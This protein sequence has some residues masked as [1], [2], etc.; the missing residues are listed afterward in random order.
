MADSLQIATFLLSKI[1]KEYVAVVLSG[2]GSDEILCG[3][4]KYFDLYKISPIRYDGK[5]NKWASK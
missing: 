1:T 2:D 5:I 4:N 3:Y